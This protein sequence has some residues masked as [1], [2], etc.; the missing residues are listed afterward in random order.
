MKKISCRNQKDVGMCGR[1]Y[2][3]RKFTYKEWKY[4]WLTKCINKNHNVYGY[5][6]HNRP[7]ISSSETTIVRTWWG[8]RRGLASN[9][10]PPQSSPQKSAGGKLQLC[11]KWSSNGP[12]PENFLTIGGY[13][14]HN[15]YRVMVLRWLKK[16]RRKWTILSFNR[17]RLATLEQFLQEFIKRFLAEIKK[18]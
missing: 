10:Q 11:S 8:R 6:S 15:T 1:S 18:M 17:F 12:S 4:H 13:F 5:V 14:E 16:E 3:Q 7:Y 2:W 9:N